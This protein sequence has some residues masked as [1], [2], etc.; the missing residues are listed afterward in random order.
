MKVTPVK[1]PTV[2]TGDD[3]F[4]LLNAVLPQLK[5]KTVVVVTGKV[6]ALCEGA[7]VVKKTGD[8]KEKHDLVRKESE[9]F[10]D[11]SQSSYDLMLTVKNQ[12]LAVNAGID[13][14]NA[15]GKYVLFPEKP[16][17]SAEKIWCYL[18]AKHHVQNLGVIIIDSRTF[19]LKWGTIGTALAHCGLAA[20]N[21]RIGEKDLFGVEMK[22]T[23]ENVVEALAVAA[24]FE[25]GEV[26]E[27]QPFAIVTDITKVQFQNR[28]PTLAEIA[29]LQI[30]I[31]DDAYAPIL[32]NAG[33]KKGGQY[34]P[35]K[36][37]SKIEWFL[38]RKI[39]DKD[40][41]WVQLK[42]DLIVCKSA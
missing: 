28:P 1:S 11:P 10:T 33:W 2:H 29:E 8:R 17:Q 5:E 6:V 19:P 7:V 18:R 13:E 25:M 23:Q 4:Q 37:N 31:H 39:A 26:D 22:M 42:I 38:D 21:N 32:K 30:S 20:L 14:S 40:E 24:N 34:L 9:L 3:L 12:I 27:A 16:Y 15:D 41:R 35:P 36:N